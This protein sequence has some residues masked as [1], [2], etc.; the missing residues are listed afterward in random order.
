MQD[1]VVRARK[2]HPRWG[3]RKLR[4]FL[5]DRNPSI[6]F[7][8][9]SA[10]ALILKRRGLIVSKRR[11]RRQR[12]DPDVS[13][14]FRDCDAPNRVWCVDFKGWF[15]M[16]DGRKC[17]PLTVTDAYSRFV[18]RCEAML[19]P[20]GTAV[21]RAFDSLFSEFGVPDAIRSDGGPP[22]AS[23]GPAGLTTLS[24]W[25]LELGIDVERI[26]PGE[27]QQNG[28]HERMHRTLKADVLPQANVR[29][30]QAAFDIWRR[31]FNEDRPHEALG[32]RPPARIYVRSTRRYPRPLQS[33]DTSDCD[34]TA[35]VDKMGMIR[36]KGRKYFISHAVRHLSLE[37]E[38]HDNEAWNVRWGTI[39]LGRIHTDRPQ[40]GLI[41]TRRRRGE[42]TVLSLRGRDDDED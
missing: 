34:Y 2:E 37:L 30:Q 26:A 35:T 22:F 41:Q 25:W 10:I 6:P 4:A 3:P 18:L 21:Q 19:T 28:R 16:A 27:P 20:D 17:Y 39:L 13:P 24:V 32:M 1:I 7:P 36:F 23:V 31:E 14:P 12:I 5:I 8:S 9:A 15:W 40:R 11:R 38:P 33:P 29:R 42:V